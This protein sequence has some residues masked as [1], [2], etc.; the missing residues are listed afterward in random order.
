MDFAKTVYRLNIAIFAVLAILN[1][2]T[3]FTPELG[4]DALWYHLTLP[5]L[6]INKHQWYFPGG[7]LYYS[8]MPRLTEIIFAPLIQISGFI[9]PK[10]IQFLSGIG[11]S[12]LI[13]KICQ[14]LKLHKNLS[15]VAVN[16]FYATWLVSWQSGSAY[17]DLFR[18]FLEISALYLLL[19]GNKISGG[20]ILGLAVGT[21]W[22]ALGSVIIYGLVF[23]ISIIPIALILAIPWFALSYFYTGNPIFPILS[24]IISHTSINPLESLGRVALLPLQITLP[25]DDFISPLSGIL[26][27][28]SA[29]LL[30]MKV[31]KK[32][33]RVA[34]IA[35]LGSASSVMLNPPSS[36]FFLPYLPAAAI[37]S[38]Y[39]LSLT[40]KKIQNISIVL[41][42]I[43]SSLIIGLRLIAFKKNIP[44]ITGK[45][46]VSQYLASQSTRLPGTFIDSDDFVK[47]NLPA[48]G[49]YLIDK[50]HN[51]FY[52]PY[53]FDHTSWNSGR[54]EYDYLVTV[55]E[56]EDK[57]G[58]KL[59]H[60][61]NLGIQIFKLK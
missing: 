49:K 5:K 57:V 21:K 53:D 45:Q 10:L 30:V 42:L 50:L 33:K 16:L 55:G 38:S 6:W 15:L 4:F 19:K 51:L 17:I 36:R 39:L 48:N 1:L 13:Y 29:I 26:L 32:V 41:I 28:L 25:F 18:T 54:E 52:F 27:S 9:G 34:L 24:P 37:A 7:L 47:T 3:V 61:N 59:I 44:Y 46:S 23:G 56:S 22:L 40:P 35:I 8:A 20:I 2:L 14:S 11:T 31:D 43:S 60:T 58:G 12:I